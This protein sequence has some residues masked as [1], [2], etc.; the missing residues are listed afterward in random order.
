LHS[1]GTLAVA[2]SAASNI[3]GYSG[4]SGMCPGADEIAG[5]QIDCSGDASFFLPYYA[6]MT[7]QERELVIEKQDTGWVGTCTRCKWMCPYSAAQKYPLGRI[8]QMFEVHSCESNGF[9]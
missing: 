7:A 9:K 5:G 8:E 1:F 2:A 6:D 3:T 4:L